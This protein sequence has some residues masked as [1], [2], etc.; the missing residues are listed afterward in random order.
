MKTL[1]VITKSHSVFDTFLTQLNDC[2]G[3]LIRIT[4]YPLDEH[5]ATPFEC[6]ICIVSYKGIEDLAK[7]LTNKK[8]IVVNR[9]LNLKNLV[10]VSSLRPGTKCLLVNNFKEAAEETVELIQALGINHLIL[11]PYYPDYSGSIDDIEVAITPGM[12]ELAPI[13]IQRVIDIGNRIIDVST[14]VEINMECGFPI[15]KSSLLTAST[16]RQIIGLTMEQSRL[17]RDLE[18]ANKQMQI[19]LDNVGD[20]IIATNEHFNI[21]SCNDMAK[22]L[23]KV[24]IETNVIGRPIQEVIPGLNL[25]EIISDGVPE[26][27]KFIQINGVSI[28]VSQTVFA[29]EV[30]A[31]GVVLILKDISEVRKGE[32]K[33]NEVTS[34]QGYIAK[35]TFSSLVCESEAMLRVIYMAQR[36]ATT[37]LPSL[38]LGE[39]GTGKELLAHA[40][41]R[42]S[43]RQKQPFLAVNLST[44]PDTLIDS[45]MFGYEEGA[46]TGAQKKG[47]P[48]FF[49][50]AHKGTIF[51]DEIG[52]IPP[53]VQVKLLRVLE[54][55]E[56]M[57]IGGAKII[58][59]DVRII[60]A[61]NRN[62]KKM[63]ENGT[64]RIDLYY[65]LCV[66]PLEIPPLRDRPEDIILLTKHFLSDYFGESPR[67]DNKLLD[68]LVSYDWPGNVREL[69]EVI[70]FCALTSNNDFKLFYNLL[71]QIMLSKI[72]S[73]SQDD[74]TGLVGLNQLKAKGNLR[75]FMGL[76]EELYLAEQKGE[77]IGRN[78]LRQRLL[79]KGINL[80]DQQVR[81]RMNYLKEI[82]SIQTGVGREG[83]FLTP[84]GLQL[85]RYLKEKNVK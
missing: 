58:P 23:M 59:I 65:R 84:Y 37:D 8:V 73:M 2:F 44:I 63:V 16:V 40:I 79:S 49:E 67:F 78:S 47:K 36:I 39:S 10:E 41:H 68:L 55:K 4:G 52:E 51:L 83:S 24:P 3:N 53:T 21:V 57:R 64:F 31:K 56:I 26:V 33:H 12:R 76:L 45:E 70:R 18:M 48:G 77:R 30:K 1:G 50:L 42:A 19:I 14:L 15:E 7:R 62:I 81:A 5:E 75:D 13:T 80:S 72:R 85:L 82:G 54:Q 60:A 6:D 38:I 71:L 22:I 27:T 74:E 46:F 34:N 43:W 29:D 9:T 61:T 28:L 32:A 35:Y 25:H 17:V 11:V 66:V 69:K 20:G